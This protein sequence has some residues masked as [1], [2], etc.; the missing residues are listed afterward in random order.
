MGPTGPLGLPR[1]CFPANFS[2]TGRKGRFLSAGRESE[3]EN[4]QNGDPAGVPMP[5]FL[6]TPVQG[7][8]TSSHLFPEKRGQ[9]DSPA[10]R[11]SWEPQLPF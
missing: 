11:L 1:L 8:L 3:K 6:L 5:E 4:K 2:S 9:R 10:T 7:D